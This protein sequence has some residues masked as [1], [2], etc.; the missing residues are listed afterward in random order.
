MGNL[1]AHSPGLPSEVYGRYVKQMLPTL[2]KVYNG[3][4]ESGKLPQS[5]NEAIIVVLLKPGKDAMLADS[6][7]PISL[8]TSDV[9]LLAKVCALR[10]SKVIHKIVGIN[11]ALFLLVPWHRILGVF[12]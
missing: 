5:M 4:L 11:V 8:S 12:S 9:K 3:A 6:Y 2:L 10:L 1:L 7:R